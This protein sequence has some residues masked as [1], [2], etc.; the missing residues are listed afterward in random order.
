MDSGQLRWSAGLL[1]KQQR[2]DETYG[3]ILH[4]TILFWVTLCVA[5]CAFR[6]AALLKHC[7]GRT[8]LTKGANSGSAAVA[9]GAQPF[10]NAVTA[11]GL[12]AITTTTTSPVQPSIP[13]SLAA[14]Q[15][16]RL[17]AFPGSTVLSDGAEVQYYDWLQRQLE[18][19]SA[20]QSPAGQASSRDNPGIDSATTA[21]NSTGVQSGTSEVKVVPTTTVVGQKRKRRAA[22]L[23]DAQVEK[24]EQLLERGVPVF[25]WAFAG[26]EA[27]TL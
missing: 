8:W 24:L 9:S 5:A 23:T 1:T 14:V 6:Y 16:C 10:A 7:E 4:Q 15:G 18:L 11:G 13:A 26:S 21:V 19:R 2:W 27:D 25:R 12:G 3:S 22:P 17:L 20:V